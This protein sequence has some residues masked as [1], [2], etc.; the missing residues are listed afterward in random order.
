MF[1]LGHPGY[2]SNVKGRSGGSNA[3]ALCDF[4]GGGGGLYPLSPS[5]FALKCDLRFHQ[6]L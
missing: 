6:E 2:E 4:P 5:G 1:V 3:L